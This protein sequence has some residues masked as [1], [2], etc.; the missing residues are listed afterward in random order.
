MRTARVPK[1]GNTPIWA[2]LVFALGTAMLARIFTAVGAPKNH[3]FRPLWYIHRL[4]I[5]I[6]SCPPK[7]DVPQFRLRSLHISPNNLR[8][9]A[10]FVASLIGL[11]FQRQCWEKAETNQRGPTTGIRMY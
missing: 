11:R 8:Q 1:T 3:G 5:L 6:V 2:L 10:L 7:Q 4:G 9:Y